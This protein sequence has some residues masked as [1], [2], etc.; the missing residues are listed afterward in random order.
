MIQTDCLMITLLE[1]Q[2]CSGQ[3]SPA[4]LA[5]LSAAAFSQRR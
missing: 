3:T 2:A 4:E 5:T 1:L